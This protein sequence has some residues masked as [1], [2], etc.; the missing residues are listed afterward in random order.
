MHFCFERLV[1]KLTLVHCVFLLL[2]SQ[3]VALKRRRSSKFPRTLGAGEKPL[4]FVSVGVFQQVELP[5]EALVAHFTFKELFW[6]L[7]FC[8]K[9]VLAVKCFWGFCRVLLLCD[10]ST[11]KNRGD[12]RHIGEHIYRRN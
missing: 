3:Q 7:G 12:K 1:T 10:T 11:N 4:F 2:V 5:A 8:S 6:L 9:R